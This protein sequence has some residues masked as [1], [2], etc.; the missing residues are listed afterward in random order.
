MP[1]CLR[2]RRTRQHTTNMSSLHITRPARKRTGTSSTTLQWLCGPGVANR[3]SIVAA[4]RR[5]E[6]VKAAICTS[7]V[8]MSIRGG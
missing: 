1:V 4:A 2:R 6:H 3:A 8:R 5:C 7:L